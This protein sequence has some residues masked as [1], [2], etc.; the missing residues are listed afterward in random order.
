MGPGIATPGIGDSRAP[1][2]DSPCCPA[3]TRAARVAAVHSGR[4]NGQGLLSHRRPSKAPRANV[5]GPMALHSSALISIHPSALSRASG[6]VL[7]ASWVLTQTLGRTPRDPSQGAWRRNAKD[8]GPPRTSADSPFR[9]AATQSAT[10]T[11]VHSVRENRQSPPSPRRPS[12]AHH[13][14]TLGPTLPL[15][16]PPPR[17]ALLLT[18]QRADRACWHPGC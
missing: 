11:S 8:W 4:E 15:E 1:A 3:T 5:P 14:K 18:A 2:P 7:P 17:A 10:G 9:P 16:A 12:K 6:S 13:A